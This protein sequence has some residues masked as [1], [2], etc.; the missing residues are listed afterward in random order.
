MTVPAAHSLPFADRLK[1][2]LSASGAPAVN[3][4]AFASHQD[5]ADP[6]SR[7]RARFSFP[8]KATV[9][10]RAPGGA[11]D[12]EPSTYLAGNSLGLMPKTTPELVRQELEVWSQRLAWQ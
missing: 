10:G 1:Q 6:F 8:T 3:S 12:D 4:P 5:A 7:F 2:D 11:G 9:A